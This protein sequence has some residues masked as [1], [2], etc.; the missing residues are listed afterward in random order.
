MY[1]LW[2]CVS[3]N[4]GHIIFT[5]NMIGRCRK[6]IEYLYIFQTHFMS[7]YIENDIRFRIIDAYFCRIQCSFTGTRIQPR[8]SSRLR[9]LSLPINSSTEPIDLVNS[10]DT[11]SEDT[12]IIEEQSGGNIYH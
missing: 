12:M 1:F 9:E 4:F 3:K 11:E 5:D 10:T 7:L 8:R 6:Y 2:V